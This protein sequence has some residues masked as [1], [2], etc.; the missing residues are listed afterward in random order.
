MEEPTSGK[1]T[2]SLELIKRKFDLLPLKDRKL[3]FES[4]KALRSNG[5]KETLGRET[6]EKVIL[7]NKKGCTCFNLV[8]LQFNY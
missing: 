1:F 8:V 4:Q 5:D 7:T 2:D 6:G 3:Y